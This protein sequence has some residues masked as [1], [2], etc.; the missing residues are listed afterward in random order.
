MSDPS[1]LPTI[2]YVLRFQRPGKPAGEPSGRAAEPGYEPVHEPPAYGSGLS[3]TTR[4]TE[5]S[6]SAEEAPVPGD[7]AV[8][9][10]TVT[11]QSDTTFSE[12]GTITFQGASPPSTLSF[13]SIGTG[14]LLAPIRDSG[15]THG[16][17]NWK[18]DSGTGAFAGATG[19]ISS[20][21]L[22]DLASDE[23][24]DTHLALV[25]LP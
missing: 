25:W 5:G 14:T 24:L 10:V 20:N 13:S 21:F 16:V 15:L 2:T 9:D 19:A 22:V 3:V 18:I 4:I 7:Q 6:V 12:S 8:L 11:Q 23:L 17:V 1:E